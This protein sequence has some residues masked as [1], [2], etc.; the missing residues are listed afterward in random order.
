MPLSENAGKTARVV[1][2]FVLMLGAGL[3]LDHDLVVT[4]VGVM[5]VGWVAMVWGMLVL[6]HNRR[7]Q[8]V[9][10]AETE[11]VEP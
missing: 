5:F 7:R 10:T 3:I 4:G 11:H 8:R 2:T 6:F 1:G 9:A